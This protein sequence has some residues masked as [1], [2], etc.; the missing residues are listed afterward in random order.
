[1]DRFCLKARAKPRGAVQC[2][3][4]AILLQPMKK[5]ISIVLGSQTEQSRYDLLLASSLETGRDSGGQLL[6]R[7]ACTVEPELV[8]PPR[9]FAHQ[10]KW[11]CQN[12]VQRVAQQVCSRGLPKDSERSAEPKIG[13]EKPIEGLA[14]LLEISANASLNVKPELCRLLHA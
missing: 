11:Y 3:S 5:P 13:V 14:S 8:Q 7:F 2:L 9:D 6:R 1:M 4:Q 12:E 10:E